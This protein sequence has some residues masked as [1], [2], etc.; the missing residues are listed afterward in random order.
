MLVPLSLWA[1]DYRLEDVSRAQPGIDYYLD[2][3]GKPVNGFVKKLV[4]NVPLASMYVENGIPSYITLYRGPGK[5]EVKNY[6]RDIFDDL[7]LYIPSIWP[8]KDGVSRRVSSAYGW[9]KSPFSDNNEQHEGIDIAVDTNSDIVATADGT[10]TFAG[11]KSGYGILV[12]LDHQNGYITRYAHNSSVTVTKGSSVARGDTIAKSGS[13]GR[14]TGPH[15]HY[16]ILV[17]EKNVNPKGYLP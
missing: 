17:Y 4:N 7:V 5:Y 10:V 2:K 9:R 12:E 15:V 1:A 8:V 14:S 13:T 16:E 6:N 3:S 11:E